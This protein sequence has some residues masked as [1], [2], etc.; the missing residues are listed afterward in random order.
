MVT[1]GAMV[2]SAPHRLP[3][4]DPL[5]TVAALGVALYHV[6]DR[7]GP[8]QLFLHGYI[9]VDL[10][11]MLSGFVLTLSFEPR[12]A[13]GLNSR[14]FLDLRIRRIW[15]LAALATLLGAVSF[16]PQAPA[17]QIFYLAILGLF[18]VPN[19]DTRF[20]LYPL[21]GVQWSLLW[22]LLANLCHVAVLRRMSNKALTLLVIIA[23]LA[24][25]TAVMTFDSGN[26]GADVSHGIFA[27]PRVTFA[28]GLGILLA[29]RWRE[30]PQA[31]FTNWQLALFLPFALAGM[32]GLVPLPYGVVDAMA[33]IVLIP[34][35]FWLAVCTRT[36]Q[37]YAA[38]FQR[39]GLVSFPLYAIH[40]PFIT[41]CEFVE[42]SGRADFIA[43]TAAVA[44]SCLIAWRW[45]ILAGMPRR[46]HIAS[47]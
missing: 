3:L 28:Y 42:D 47:A 8:Q 22:E 6:H 4:L 16:L 20:E 44:C 10:F 45:P 32:L 13:A 38:T 29:R 43:L 1:K 35:L 25:A 39:I 15:P 19:L 12:F 37:Q 46:P 2:S 5:R 17:G 18:M 33:G 31:P 11:F 14:S 41:A 34:G 7:M 23:G 21:S 36:P 9:L 27:L 24:H 26:L 30:Y 40:V